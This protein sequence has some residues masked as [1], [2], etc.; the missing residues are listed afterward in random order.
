MAGSKKPAPLSWEP[1]RRGLTF[2]SPACGHGCKVVDHDRAV[3]ASA[4]LA[5]GLGEGWAPRVWENMGWHWTVQHASGLE[6]YPPRYNDDFSCRVGP[7]GQIWPKAKT[8]RAAIKKALVLYK[9]QLDQ[10]FARWE[11]LRKVL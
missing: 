3:L 1:E 4:E 2:C 9:E 11:E 6:I 5:K 7:T 10:Q 8:A